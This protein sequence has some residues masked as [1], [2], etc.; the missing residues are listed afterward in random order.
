MASA[1]SPLRSARDRGAA[2]PFRLLWPV[3]MLLCC[4][5][6][7]HGAQ[8]ESAEGRGAGPLSGRRGPVWWVRCGVAGAGGGGGEGGGGPR[9][10]PVP[11]ASAAAAP[12]AA[13]PGAAPLAAVSVSTAPDEAGRTADGGRP[14]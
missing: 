1:W 10:G 5:T 12:H 8:A 11:A 3:L 9:A 6:V 2:V 4:G 7:A 14:A 13:A